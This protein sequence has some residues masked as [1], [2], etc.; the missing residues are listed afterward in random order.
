MEGDQADRKKAASS[1]YINCPFD[2]KF[3][4]VMDAIV[5]S[6]V[7]CGVVPRTATDT[8][9]VS[10]ARMDRIRDAMSECRYSIH[11]LSRSKGAG[12]ENFARAN[13]PLELGMAISLRHDW[14]ALVAKDHPYEKFIS[15]LAGYDLKRHDETPARAISAV[16]SWLRTRLNR[17]TLTP[18]EVIERFDRFQELVAVIDLEL[19][20]EPPAEEIRFAAEVALGLAAMPDKWRGKVSWET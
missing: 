9:E 2:D 14:L 16:V 1:V 7:A 20:D 17:N 11:D 10:R 4:S 13:M 19:W 15:N 8:G 12:D 6:V 3:K 18:A 5:L